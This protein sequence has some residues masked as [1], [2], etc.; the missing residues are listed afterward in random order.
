[1]AA[2]PDAAV[3]QDR[4]GQPEHELNNE[5][6]NDVDGRYAQRGADSSAR[7]DALPDQ[8]LPIL[9]PDRLHLPGHRI[10]LLKAVPDVVEEWVDT[11]EKEQRDDGK[12]PHPGA[13]RTEIGA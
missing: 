3:D 13:V 1:E 6:C 9:E 8:P 7:L 4:D 12:Q 10:E 5:R 11:D 2:G